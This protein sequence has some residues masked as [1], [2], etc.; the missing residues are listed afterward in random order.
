[1]GREI[2]KNKQTEKAHQRRTALHLMIF[3]MS[4]AHSADIDTE[5]AVKCWYDV[6]KVAHS[7]TLVAPLF[8]SGEPVIAG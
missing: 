7:I 4:M 5:T 2:K 3:F 1:M 6:N 8:S